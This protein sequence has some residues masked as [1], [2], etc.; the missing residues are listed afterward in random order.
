[1]LE[2]LPYQTNAGGLRRGTRHVKAPGRGRRHAADLKHHLRALYDALFPQA[3]RDGLHDA[4]RLLLITD[5]VLD[6]VPFCA[7]RTPDEQWLVERLELQYWPSVTA[8]MLTRSAVEVRRAMAASRASIPSARVAGAAS[9]LHA[10]AGVPAASS[11]SAPSD[12][13]PAASSPVAPPDGAPAASSPVAPPD[14]A[15]TVP[16]PPSPRALILGDPAFTAKY[17]VSLHGRRLELVFDQLPGTRLEAERIGALLHA[18]PR[19]DADASLATVM[20]EASG[21]AVLHLATHGVLDVE[22]PEA[23]FVALADGPLTAG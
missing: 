3:L 16:T 5:G 22:Q 17:P 11:P 14:G 21:C 20:R 8:W 15:Q 10:G 9:S 12:G 4:K 19:L 23:S 18:T 1:V 6:Y 2:R 7:L 13:A